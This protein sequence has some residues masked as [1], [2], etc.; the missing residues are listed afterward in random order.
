VVI[1]IGYDQTIDLGLPIISK[2]YTILTR[3]VINRFVTLLQTDCSALSQNL[4]PKPR[5]SVLQG[6]SLPK[7]DHVRGFPF[8]PN[9]TGLTRSNLSANLRKLEEV[10]YIDI[11]KEFVDRVPRSLIRL[12][13]AG[14]EALEGY[15]RNMQLILNEL[16]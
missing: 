5:V 13:H 16:V 3:L 4:I 2:L 7:R 15:K 10:G 1:P 12:N 9:Q 11:K 6:T 14:R 8:L